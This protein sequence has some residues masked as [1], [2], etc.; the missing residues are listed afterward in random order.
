MLNHMSN[1]D[2]NVQ[3]YLKLCKLPMVYRQIT[4]DS[5]TGPCVFVFMYRWKGSPCYKHYKDDKRWE[6]LLA[7]WCIKDDIAVCMPFHFLH[8]LSLSISLLWQLPRINICSFLM[9]NVS[10][11][12]LPMGF[13]YRHSPAQTDNVVTSFSPQGPFHP[14]APGDCLCVISSRSAEK[15]RR[16]SWTNY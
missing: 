16:R 11:S 3:Y 8:R 15:L 13:P 10:T 5:E 14:A 12:S 2:I 4:S 7:L 9:W 6:I 1:Q